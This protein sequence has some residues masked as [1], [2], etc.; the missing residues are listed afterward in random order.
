M[1]FWPLNLEDTSIFLCRVCCREYGHCAWPSV[2]REIFWPPNLRGSAIFSC[3]VCCFACGYSRRPYAFLA[4]F[5][6]PNLGGN[7]ISSCRVCYIA[8][9]LCRRP[10]VFLIFFWPS[11]SGGSAISSCSVCCFASGLCRR[12][13]AFPTFFLA[14]QIERQCDLYMFCLLLR[15]W[16][17]SKALCISYFLFC[18]PNSGGSAMFLFCFCYS[19]CRTPRKCLFDTFLSMEETAQKPLTLHLQRSRCANPTWIAP[20]QGKPSTFC[21]TNPS[22]RLIF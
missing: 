17:L 1:F 3:R 16:A 15:I 11:E 20:K 19:K 18:S 8:S 10:C 7:A 14:F 2:F 12:P 6:P 13:C 4:F 21:V 9:K 5:W 22:L